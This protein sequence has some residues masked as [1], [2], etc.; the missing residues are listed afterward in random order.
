[1]GTFRAA[2]AVLLGTSLAG[3][4]AGQGVDDAEAEG[5]EPALAQVDQPAAV[6]ASRLD[7][8]APVNAALGDES[9]RAAFDAD[10]GPDADASDRI[11]V[12]LAYVE[13]R[14]R[15]RDVSHLAPA[16]RLA[17]IRNLDRLH[18]YW[19]A[20]LFPEGDVEGARRPRFVDEDPDAPLASASP[21]RLCAV[22]HLLALDL[23]VDAARAISVDFQHAAIGDIRSDALD[24]WAAD[25]GLT[26]DELAAIQPQYD[27]RRPLPQ[28]VRV[29][30]ER[31]RRMLQTRQDEVNA[32]VHDR[33]G[34]N[35]A[36]PDRIDARVTVAMDGRVTSVALSTG[37]DRHD[38]LAVQACV[39]RELSALRFPRFRGAD[40]IGSATFS[41]IGPTTRGKLNPAY[42]P[43]VFRRAEREV[44]ACAA[45]VRA[46]G[47]HAPRE[48]AVVARLEPSGFFSS[49][50]IVSSEAIGDR[51]LER[52]V[53]RVLRMQELP[54]FTGSAQQTSHAFVLGM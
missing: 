41:V 5:A 31:V 11:R 27:F 46:A 6:A 24:A 35:Q 36:H 48:V 32:C 8:P 44:R 50:D 42:L 16:Q 26:L 45:A 51:P 53:R 28:P 54:R 30:P 7:A 19:N 49:V 4:L 40:V 3:C 9:W 37:L 15:A 47:M 12:H 34:A 1:M 52:C 14:L 20:G 10:P 43:V 18:A 33:L 17:R 21:T 39:A 22:G 2:V 25:S 23:G 29:D 38:D 13:A